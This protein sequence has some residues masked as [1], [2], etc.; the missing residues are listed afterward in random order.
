MMI[1]TSKAQISDLF[2]LLHRLREDVQTLELA[3]EQQVVSLRGQ[4]TVDSSDAI[5]LSFR[6]LAQQIT[7]MEETL[8]AIAEATGEVCKPG[9]GGR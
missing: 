8:A 6:K 5:G 7:S 3:Q 9:L 4:Q 2:R 1:R